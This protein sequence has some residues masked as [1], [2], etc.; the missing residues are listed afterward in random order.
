MVDLEEGESLL[1]AAKD[2]DREDYSFK[3]AFTRWI[4]FGKWTE[5]NGAALIKEIRKLQKKLRSPRRPTL[6]KRH[7][8]LDTSGYGPG[9]DIY[10]ARL[11]C[12]GCQ[13]FSKWVNKVWERW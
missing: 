13:K 1:A 12:T 3:S 4:A 5:S 9:I 11:D 7:L 6:C 2:L 8:D 10:S